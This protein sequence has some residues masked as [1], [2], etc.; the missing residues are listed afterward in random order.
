MKHFKYYFSH[1]F[2]NECASYKLA[3]IPVTYASSVP[4]PDFYVFRHSET[5]YSWCLA[6]MNR[7][8]G[9]W[10]WL[11]HFHSF[12]LTV[13]LAFHFHVKSKTAPAQL[14]GSPW[15]WCSQSRRSVDTN[16][17]GGLPHSWLCRFYVM[18]AVV[19]SC[20]PALHDKL[21]NS[22]LAIL[23]CFCLIRSF[24]IAQCLGC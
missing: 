17:W 13:S 8:L 22:T 1:I 12:T 7:D 19:C 6:W 14:H 16:G 18:V 24:H 2:K 9:H 15:C 10:N 4:A 21:C 3:L 11:L 20:V 5:V 23:H